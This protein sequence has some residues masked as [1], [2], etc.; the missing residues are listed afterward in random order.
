VLEKLN[1]LE[2]ELRETRSVSLA[3]R[4]TVD[5]LLTEL[6]PPLVQR[7][8]D[9]EQESQANQRLRI[10]KNL[11][12]WLAVCERVKAGMSIRQAAK[13]LDLP[14]STAWHYANASEQEALKLWSR[15]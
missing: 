5:R 14:Y 11:K 8:K 2:S 12:D 10:R 6:L 4:V 9:L 3:L 1:Q 7:V 15:G 13:E